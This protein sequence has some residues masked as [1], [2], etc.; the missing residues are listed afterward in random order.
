MRILKLFA[1]VLLL[2]GCATL[3]RTDVAAGCQL[4]DAATTAYGLHAGLTDMNP[5][6]R[7]YPAIALLTIGAQWLIR[8]E[9]NKTGNAVLSSALCTSAVRN[10]VLMR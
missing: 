9:E 10:L 2:S 8:R 6:M 5:L 3:E 4:A 1:F 7:T